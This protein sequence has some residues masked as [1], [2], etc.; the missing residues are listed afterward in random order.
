MVGK[1]PDY[2]VSLKKAALL[3]AAAKYITVVLQLIYTAV[4][5]RI[6][7]PEEYGIVAIIN[8]FI[9]FFQLFAD[10][11]LS[12]GVIQ[13]RNL[14]IKEIN[15][16]FS[17]T[18]YMGIGLLLLFFAFSFPLSV[19]YKN[20]IYI[21][22]GVELAFSLMF[23]AFNMIPNAILLKEKKFI[24]IAVRTVIVSGISFTLTIFFAV[25]GFGVFALGANSVITALGMFCWNEALTRLRFVFKPCYKSVKKIWGYSMFQ[26]AAQALNYFNR[27][28]DNLL[29]GRFYSAAELGQYNKAYTLMQ[30]PITYLPGVI[31]PVLHP[32]LSE[33]QED[34]EY[35]Y[36][37]YLRLL[38]LLSLIGCFGAAACFF[39]GREIIL[40]IFGTQWESAILPFRILGL[41]LWTQIL[42]NTMAPIYQS[43]GNTK[44]MFKSTIVTT[45]LIVFSIIVGF[46]G[47]NI[48]CIALAISCGY[49]INF[50]VTYYIMIKK[51]F[52]KKLFDFL[53]N[54][55]P[56]LSIFI[57]LLIVAIFWPFN[58]NSLF[59]GFIFKFSIYFII[60]IGMLFLTKQYK[61]I[62][63]L[64]KKN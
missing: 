61:I 14:S 19:I 29:I 47:G 63:S 7:T 6:L 12:T 40:I 64:I 13:N 26:F 8:V 4:L 1:M 30:Y 48:V 24:S 59:T 52:K 53:E 15:H 39:L 58:I 16:I 18:V 27:N 62:V 20:K 9:V 54:F 32:V 57:V 36:K 50:F 23:N 45:A 25:N 35:I 49:I 38:K 10:M 11:G 3:N 41:S 31:T 46:I 56:E 5:S 42:T 28:L 17:I 22:L 44:L 51:C 43:V 33:Y 2:S 37:T 55:F 21:P 60:Y 34:K